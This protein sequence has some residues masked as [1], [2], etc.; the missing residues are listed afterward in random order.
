MATA[1]WTYPRIDNFG[2]IDPAGNFWKPDSNVQ[3]PGN[4]PIVAILSGT[5]TS[6]RNT[7][8]GQSVV[9]IKLDTPQNSLATHAFYEHMSSAAVRVGQ[10]VNQNDLIGYN[11]PSGQVP[12]GFGFYS[13]DVYGSGSAWTQLQ[14]DLCP[15]CPNLLNPVKFLNAAKGGSIPAGSGSTK[16]SSVDCGVDPVCMITQWWVTS[17]MPTFKQWGEYAAIFVIALM[18]LIVGFFL[19]NEQSATKLARKVL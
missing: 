9:T 2:M 12:L 11:N 10:H 5:V 17:L 1:W 3:V 8:F 7:D 4:Y 19:L 14:K 18:L 16:T 6:V 15:G 13:G